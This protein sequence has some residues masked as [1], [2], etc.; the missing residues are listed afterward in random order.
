M[1]EPSTPDA[2][3][4]RQRHLLAGIEDP[5][6]VALQLRQVHEEFQALRMHYEFGIEEVLTKVTILRKEFEQVHDYSP[7]EHVRTRLKSVESLVEKALRT[8]GEM[9]VAAIRERI[10]DIAGIRITC[11]FPSDAYWVADMLAAQQDIEVLQVKDYIAHPKP[12]GY[13]SLHLIVK[14]PVFL[15][16]H[17]EL[18]P[19]ELQIRSIAMDFWASVEHKLSYKYE[20]NLPEHLRAE[21]D[22]AARVAREL[23]ARM[24]NLRTEI[25]PSPAPGTGSGLFFHAP[26][27]VQDPPA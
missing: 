22:D 6:Q 26:D 17:T 15:S 25:R 27:A 3:T 19:V 1:S 8:G 4:V 12:N 2:I 24:E 21:L 13:R 23:D 9:T 5:E 14:V 10:H 18:V 7:I 11:S 20:K 16:T